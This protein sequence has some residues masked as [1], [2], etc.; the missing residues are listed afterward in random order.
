MLADTI[1]FTPPAIARTPGEMSFTL[2]IPTD[3]DKG[4][5]G[6]RMKRLGVV[7]PD[8]AILRARIIEAVFELW[9]PAEAE[10]KAKFL[11]AFWDAEEIYAQA[12]SE[13]ASE[14]TRGKHARRRPRS[15]NDDTKRKMADDLVN[16]VRGRSTVVRALFVQHLYFRQR[17]QAMLARIHI[18]EVTTAKPGV[19]CPRLE[20][21]GEL[22]SEAALSALQTAVGSTAW[23]QLLLKLDRLYHDDNLDVPSPA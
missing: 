7:D 10:T 2:S 18:R 17:V 19:S 8:Q 12:L 4:L 13:W 9:L 16:D 14:A 23:R 21:V 1:E 11:H 22:L 5:L 15:P 20:W 3:D 6:I